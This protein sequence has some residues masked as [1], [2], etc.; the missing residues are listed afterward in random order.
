MPALPF[1]LRY[2]LPTVLSDILGRVTVASTL[3]ILFVAGSIYWILLLLRGTT[4]M[5]VLRGAVVVLLGAFLLSRL[6]DLRVV[7]WLLRNS[8]TGLVVGLAV[9]FQPEIRRA[10]ERLGRTGLRS[11]GNRE[12]HLHAVDT[13]VRAAARLSRQRRGALIVIERE[14]GLGDVIDTGILVD[15]AL[16]TE[17]LGS[18][19]A[20]NT[21]LHD[22]AVVVRLDRVVAAGCTLPLSES[23]LPSEFGMRHRAALGITEGTDAVVVVVSEE[24]GDLS[25][26]SNGRMI[27]DLDEL[28]LSWQLH[29]LLNLGDGSIE[30]PRAPERVS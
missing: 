16:S 9:V 27:T 15:A 8:I 6:L 5:T 23:V 25:L 28:R 13:V 17:L 30:A 19:F 10:L 24:R 11:L 12:E 20:P 14:T 29:R 21:P 7:N 22:G 2:G 3:D 4:A 1:G 26:A 18:I